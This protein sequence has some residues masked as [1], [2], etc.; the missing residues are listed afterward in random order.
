VLDH[1]ESSFPRCSP[2]APGDSRHLLRNVKRLWCEH[3]AKDRYYEIKRMI[4]D[5]MQIGRIAFLKL[6][7]REAFFHCTSVSGINK[8]FR[9]IDA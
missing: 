1:L 3:G 2:S 8:I 9:D 7:I 5:L 4:R 6:A